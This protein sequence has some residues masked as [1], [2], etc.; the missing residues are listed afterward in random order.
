MSIYEEL[1]TLSHEDLVKLSGLVHK[2][3]QW[4][5]LMT[6]D[7]A[8]QQAYDRVMEDSDW[9]KGLDMDRKITRYC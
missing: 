4:D 2:L 7:E 3:L 8:L 5:S 9:M 6:W 1:S